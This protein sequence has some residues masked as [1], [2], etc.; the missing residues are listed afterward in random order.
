MMEARRSDTAIVQ[1]PAG[2][3]SAHA[4]EPQHQTCFDTLLDQLA[5]DV[6]KVDK[7]EQAQAH[8]DVASEHE[9]P[10]Q[11]S[12][13][14]GSDSVQ[15]RDGKAAFY[16][17]SDNNLKDAL[18][19]LVSTSPAEQESKSSPAASPRLAEGG[20]GGGGG[21]RISP[22]LHPVDRQASVTSVTSVGHELPLDM[23][24]GEH[25]VV[26]MV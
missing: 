20:V 13:T 14:L 11:Q 2:A 15:A 4:C 17:I 6:D 1:S 8:R 7:G 25:G 10:R 16:Y 19:V 3:Q 24:K 18:D 22:A 23:Q 21:S 12:C 9:A 26:T 5:H